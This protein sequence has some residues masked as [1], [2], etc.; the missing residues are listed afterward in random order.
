MCMS[1]DVMKMMQMLGGQSGI[2]PGGIPSVEGAETQ[3]GNETS[4][5]D[6]VKSLLDPL[7]QKKGLA[8]MPDLSPI[9][10]GQGQQ[11]PADLASLIFGS[12]R[13]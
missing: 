4:A 6:P 7:R 2:G 11:V 8:S 9:Q 3:F 12:M 1:P 10:P 13:R 5:L